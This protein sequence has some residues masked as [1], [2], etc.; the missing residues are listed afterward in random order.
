MF[1]RRCKNRS[2]S[3]SVQIISKEKGKYTVLETLGSAKNPEE[4]E[5]LSLKAQI[6]LRQKQ[7]PNQP[8]L[9]VYPDELMMQNFVE[10]LSNSNIHT[11][12]PEL[13]FGK[14]FDK[15]GFG[16]IKDKLFRYVT[17]A[18]LTYPTSKLKT[19][20]YL[21]RYKNIRISVDRI[22]R[23]LDKLNNTYKDQVEKIAFQY[24]KKIL[25]GIISVVFYDLTTL[26]FEAEDEDDLRKIGFSKDGKFQKPQI[27]LG[28][29]TGKNGYPI[30]YDIFEGNTFEGFT[31]LPTLKKIQQKYGFPKPIVVADSGLLSKDNIEKLK[32]EKYQFIIGARIKNETN[33]IKQKILT[34]AQAMKDGD[35]FI[36]N[37]SNE[38][39]LIIT[40]SEKRAKKDAHNRER[41]LAKLQQ[42]V[43]SGKLTK[44]H[45]NNRG[46]NKFL[47]LKGNVTI[48]I[49]QKKIKKDQQWDGLK[50][51]L[52]NTELTPK[53]VIANYGNLWQIE[54]AFRISK[55][56]LKIRPIYHY[57]KKRI[58]AHICIAF[59][60]YTIYKELERI[61]QKEK[62]SFS[63]KRA[64]ELTD[65]MYEIEYFL[66][67]SLKKVKTI[68]KMDQEQKLLKTIIEK[69]I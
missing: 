54:K 67:K 34:Q 5:K 56:D 18:R 45:I 68:L 58:Q 15:I 53:E 43:K 41:G 4:L 13:I 3:I 66:P 17:I 22:Y 10:N 20:D 14:L 37:K 64:C 42:K 23:F 26:Y 9:I 24:T 25:K 51:Y 1:I 32:E 35:S 61:L 48:K 46:Y 50:G 52:T 47:Q 38:I 29:L 11:I 59:V 30:G 12:G 39:R 57:R 6:H 28:L 27:M 69:N 63:V 31:L 62:V 36:I 60:A 49:D 33:E 16:E 44:S 21:L 55:T 65:N 7:F 40:Y 8:T 2:G 19:A